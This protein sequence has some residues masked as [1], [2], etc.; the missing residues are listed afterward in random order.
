MSVYKLT[1][2]FPKEEIYG[3]TSQFRRASISIPANIAQ[4]LLSECQYYLILSRELKYSND[5]A[6]FDLANE[7]GKLLNSYIKAIKTNS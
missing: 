5:Q 3:L 7:V 1:K 4:G 6:I 2:L